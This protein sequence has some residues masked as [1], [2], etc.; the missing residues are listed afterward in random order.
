MPEIDVI[1][2]NMQTEI[3]NLKAQ[4]TIH[5]Q[6]IERLR[7]ERDQLKERLIQQVK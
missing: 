6:E 1:I 3:M 4:Q 5:L 7:S 2:R